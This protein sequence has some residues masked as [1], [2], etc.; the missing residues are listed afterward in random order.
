MSIADE[1]NE[2]R[3]ARLEADKKVEF[4]KAR[5]TELKERIIK[6]MQS[7]G[8]DSMGGDACVVFLNR[9]DEPQATDW[10]AIYTYIAANDAFELLHRRLTA[11]AIKERKENGENIP[12][13][14][15]YPVYSL[16][17]KG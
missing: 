8:E 2:A 7:T 3:K 9:K 14:A 6:L 13:I 4:L 5:E 15:W 11:T 12:G 1:Y 10:Q 16:S 17:V